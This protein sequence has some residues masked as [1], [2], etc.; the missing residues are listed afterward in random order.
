MTRQVRPTR[1]AEARQMQ[2]GGFAGPSRASASGSAEA[3]SASA[4]GAQRSRFTRHTPAPAPAC[5][6][7]EHNA[8]PAEG[9]SASSSAG[10][11]YGSYHTGLGPLAGL[12]NRPR[13]R[14]VAGGVAAA[15]AASLTALPQCRA[16]LTALPGLRA[17]ASVCRAAAA[18]SGSGSAAGADLCNAPLAGGLPL[19]LRL[20]RCHAFGARGGQG[21]GDSDGEASSS[22]SGAKI[23]CSECGE[24]LRLT[25]VKGHFERGC[26][27]LPAGV[28]ED[29]RSQLIRQH[30]KK[31]RRANGL[32]GDGGGSGHGMLPSRSARTRRTDSRST[33]VM[34]RDDNSGSCSGS[35]DG[36]EGQGEAERRQG[37]RGAPGASGAPGSVASRS[38]NPGHNSA[39]GTG[40]GSSS[41]AN[42]TS[43]AAAGTARSRSGS[44]TGAAEA[45]SGSS[46][47]DA[48]G[49]ASGNA[50]PAAAG[51]SKRSTARSSPSRWTRPA[52]ADDG[53]GAG[54]SVLDRPPGPS[55]ATVPGSGDRDGP[56]A[57]AAAAGGAPLRGDVLPLASQADMNA[58]AAL[59][60]L[61]LPV[62]A[63]AVAG[64]TQADGLLPQPLQG[65]PS[66]SPPGSP[67][68]A[69]TSRPD[70]LKVG[71]VATSGGGA[72]RLPA[73][74]S[75]PSPPAAPLPSAPTASPVASLSAS[76]AVP[77]Q[78]GTGPAVNKPA[79]ALG[80]WN[81]MTVTQHSRT[82]GAGSVSP[83]LSE[84]RDPSKRPEQ[85]AAQP[86]GTVPG[87]AAPAPPSPAKTQPPARGHGADTKAQQP[88]QPQ[89]QGP[90]QEPDEG[91]P[92]PVLDP[93]A[94]AAE[95][96]HVDNGLTGSRRAMA[97]AGVEASARRAAPV[98]APASTAG[99][100]TGRAAG[101]GAGGQSQDNEVAL[102]V[103]RVWV[104]RLG[105][106]WLGSNAAGW[107]RIACAQCQSMCSVGAK[108]PT[109]TLCNAACARPL[110]A[111]LAA[112]SAGN[113]DAERRAAGP[114]Q[115]GLQDA[116]HHFP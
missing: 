112:V 56:G 99:P 24:P 92:V 114:H 60:D 61:Q 9:A 15:T 19:R 7:P 3:P 83:P 113:D 48:G 98:A 35:E 101:T 100:G 47:N 34:L 70:W 59:A 11:R 44:S 50:V 68:A 52:S 65:S 40:V 25:N 38:R 105:G 55:D 21:G 45:S 80:T 102:R 111:C 20:T 69:S 53:G 67:P 116:L 64:L 107:S 73:P 2:F 39:S 28:T 110:C 74:S 77:V 13:R 106:R 72:G 46:R 94:V 103:G 27:K 37:G 43:S 88:A 17:T 95:A 96:A 30:E 82:S 8:A 104:W 84:Q 78:L 87:A 18:A 42:G 91:V 66:G 29:E 51:A 58:G 79:G 26:R 16:P 90:G 63:A 33:M 36:A 71:P 49:S 12:I 5:I 97:V 85:T 81:S 41:D 31:L 57:A 89:A 93:V 1:P 75:A 32:D 76:A 10:G 54:T 108:H 4:S 62:D 23:N 109:I 115:K 86:R 6:G 14:H 22:L